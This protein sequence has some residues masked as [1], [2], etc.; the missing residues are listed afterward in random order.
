MNDNYDGNFNTIQEEA[1]YRLDIKKVLRDNNI[2]FDKMAKT[3]DLERLKA[4]VVNE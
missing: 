2:P 4:L 1:R 3:S